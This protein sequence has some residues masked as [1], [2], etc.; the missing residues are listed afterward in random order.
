MAFDWASNGHV[1]AKRCANV[2]H[3][4]ESSSGSTCSR[5]MGSAAQTVQ[6]SAVQRSAVQCSAVVG[7]AVQKNCRVA[8][9]AAWSQRNT[10]TWTLQA[11]D[12]SK[13][14]GGSETAA[15]PRAAAWPRQGC[16]R[17]TRHSKTAA[18]QQDCS[19]GHSMA[20]AWLTAGH[21]RAAVELQAATW[22]QQGCTQG[23]R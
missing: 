6:C 12:G 13:T 7:L 14:T 8:Q 15:E 10:S 21:S 23:H 11:T 4:G 19:H 16:R 9:V 3:V 22:P 1:W 2:P 17:A 18:W 20:T 5:W